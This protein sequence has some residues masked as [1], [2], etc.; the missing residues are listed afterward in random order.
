MKEKQGTGAKDLEVED[1][2]LYY[3]NRQFI[4]SKEQLLTDLAKR[5]CDYKVAAHFGPEKTNE[6]VTSVM[7]VVIF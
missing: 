5:S 4:P 3:N 7:G 1:G 6:L 2:L